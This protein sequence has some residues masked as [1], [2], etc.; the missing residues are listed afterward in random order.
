MRQAVRVCNAQEHVLLLERLGVVRIP[1]GSGGIA[2]NAATHIIDQQG[3]L[4]SIIDEDRI[5]EAPQTLLQLVS[6]HESGTRHEL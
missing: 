2:H 6:R 4:V 3:R 5:D 1:D